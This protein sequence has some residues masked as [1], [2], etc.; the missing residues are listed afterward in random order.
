VSKTGFALQELAAC[1][2]QGFE[3]LSRSDLEGVAALMEIAEGHL[4][5]LPPANA[6]SIVEQRLRNAAMAARGRLAH[7]LQSGL[8][9]VRDELGKVRQG[10]RALH[11]YKQ[12]ADGLGARV[13]HDA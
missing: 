9:A 7:G 8:S 10:A 1:W 12:P 11:G 13:R 3:A 4:R 2:D 5:D 6:D